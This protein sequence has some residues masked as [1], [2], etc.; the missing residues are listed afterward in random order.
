MG[1]WKLIQNR[2]RILGS[3][4]FELFDRRHDPHELVNLAAKRPE[5]VQRLALQ[6]DRWR[7]RV[8]AQRKDDQTTGKHQTIDS[9]VLKRLRSLG[10]LGEN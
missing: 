1:D 9:E 3:E 7:I 6:L 5:M 10:Y 8:I 4:E 2:R